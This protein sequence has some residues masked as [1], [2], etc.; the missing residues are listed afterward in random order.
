MQ[1]NAPSHR[2]KSTAAWLIANEV[3]TFAWPPYSPDL[4]PIENLWGWLARKIYANGRQFDSLDDL[5][6]EIVLQ[7][8]LIPSDRTKT[9]CTS[10]KNRLIKVIQKKE[11]ASIIDLKTLMKLSNVQTF[12]ILFSLKII[13]CDLVSDQNIFYFF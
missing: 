11:V 9:L 10:I 7:W 5:K 12:V 2:S 13:E 6:Q 8:S 4:N 1:D 3:E